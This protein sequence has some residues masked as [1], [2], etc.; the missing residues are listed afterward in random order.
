MAV[1]R[2]VLLIVGIVAVLAGLF[3]AAQGLDWIHWPLS[4]PMLDKREWVWR[5]LGVA[6]V[7]L[8]LVL[9]TTL[10]RRR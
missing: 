5:G 4:S 1:L 6:V 2:P 8:L 10:R 3:F 7:G 9:R